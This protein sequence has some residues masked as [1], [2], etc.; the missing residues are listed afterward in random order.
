MCFSIKLGIQVG[1]SEK[2]D[3]I[4]FRGHRSDVKVTIH[5]YGKKL[6]NMKETKSLC[7]SSSNLA[8]LLTMVRGWNSIDFGGHRSEVKATIG[9]TYKYG[10]CGDATL[11]VV[12]FSFCC[13]GKDSVISYLSW[14]WSC[15]CK[16]AFTLSK[17]S[18]SKSVKE[19]LV[20]VFLDK[21]N[22]LHY[23]SYLSNLYKKAM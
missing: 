20:K 9:I 6:V 19:N 3:S 17:F 14:C 15:I 18:W 22:C 10:V 5:I 13:C 8:D 2:M 16:A 21:V 12:I 4:D 23:Q 7:A 11:W 1:H